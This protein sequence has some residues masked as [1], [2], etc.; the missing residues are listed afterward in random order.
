MGGGITEGL[1]VVSIGE[2]GGAA[3]DGATLTVGD[4]EIVALLDAGDVQPASVAATTQA[5]RRM[6]P[7]RVSIFYDLTAGPAERNA[8]D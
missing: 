5:T 2:G 3:G 4:G 1:G 7:R 6:K 8:L